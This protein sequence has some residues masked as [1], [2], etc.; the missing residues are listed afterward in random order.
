MTGK[1][2]KVRISGF[3]LKKRG[4]ILFK[5]WINI[6]KKELNFKRVNGWRI[7]DPVNIVSGC[8]FTYRPD[9]ETVFVNNFLR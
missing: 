7:H 8:Q 1:E 9:Y 2:I 3:E 4:G 6:E 5:W